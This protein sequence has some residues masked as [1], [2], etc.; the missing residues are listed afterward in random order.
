MFFF[1]FFKNLTWILR[2]SWY[3]VCE[4][5]TGK[6]FWASATRYVIHDRTSC[7]ESTRS[8]ARVST[9]LIYTSRVT[10]T[11]WINCTFWSTIWWYSNESVRTTARVR[12]SDCSADGIG[13]AGR[14]VARITCTDYL[15]KWINI[16]V[17]IFFW[18]HLSSRNKNS[19]G[20]TS[21]KHLVN[22]S[23]VVLTGQLQIGL[24]FWTRQMAPWPH[25]FRHGSWHFWLMQ[26]NRVS[27]S[28]LIVHSGLQFGGDPI[29][30]LRQ[31]QTAWPFL[32]I[33]WL[34]GPHGDKLQGLG[35]TIAEK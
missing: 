25:R 12:L 13:S 28:E 23:P 32:S 16:L 20:S 35:S 30:S 27:H 1:F 18:L 14:W 2:W 19:L 24:W 33:H 4:R 22:A 6:S 9:L 7:R 26:A 11:I 29:N 17:C 8:W 15:N 5:V 34:F 21:G 3:A 10:G 31:V